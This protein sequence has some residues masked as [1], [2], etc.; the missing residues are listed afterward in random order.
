MPDCRA[1]RCAQ[2]GRLASLSDLDQ[3]SQ[4]SCL[5]KI[6]PAPTKSR[7]SLARQTDGKT[8]CGATA[9]KA[10]SGPKLGPDQAPTKLAGAR[11]RR[12]ERRERSETG[13][14]PSPDQVPTKLQAR[15]GQRSPRRWPRAVRN[16]VPTKS[17]PSSQGPKATT[18]E[19]EG[20][21][22]LGPDQVPTKPAWARGNRVEE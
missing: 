14:R 19:T 20:G 6:G 8:D 22:K 15:R 21:P 10:E 5:L 7:L 13:P 18:P 1:L 4:E 16:A 12:A 9:P 11:G 3:R 2:E 17:R